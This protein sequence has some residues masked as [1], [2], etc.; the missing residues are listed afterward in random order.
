VSF[1]VPL[2]KL[3]SLSVFDPGFTG[4]HFRRLLTVPVYGIAFWTTLKIGLLVT[5]ACLVLGYPVAFILVHAPRRLR[6]WILICILLPFWTSVL[7][8][9][10]AWMVL[11]Q[12]GG[13]VMQAVRVVLGNAAPTLMFNLTGVVIGMVHYLLPFMV[14]ALAS[15]MRG[16][17]VRYIQAAE[18]LG[19]GP[20]RTWWHVYLPLTVPGIRS[21]SILVFVM[22]LGFFVTPAL[23]GSRKESTIAM[24]IG[25]HIEEFLNWGFGA[26]LSVV[27]LALS[28]VILAPAYRYVRLGFAGK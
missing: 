20:M 24:L 14:F 17:D 28:L 8:R 15:V 3:L 27:L 13:P 5:A 19:G 21:G 10:Y 1:Y 25:I 22:A 16:I 12:D 26:A 4:V 23:L 18:S 9:A 7:V 6:P 2:G 11:L